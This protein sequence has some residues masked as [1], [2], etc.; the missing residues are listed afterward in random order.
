MGNLN[1][2]KFSIV[3]MQRLLSIHTKSLLNHRKFSVC[4]RNRFHL[5]KDS[6][7]LTAY[8]DNINSSFSYVVILFLLDVNHAF[9]NPKENGYFERI[10]I[11]FHFPFQ[12]TTT[13]DRKL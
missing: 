13:L 10:M 7:I 12:V 6:V 9:K 4:L 2:S 3:P 5:F 8:K 11:L 1:F